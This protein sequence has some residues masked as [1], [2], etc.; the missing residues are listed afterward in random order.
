MQ[1]T[2]A[3]LVQPFWP[4][5]TVPP[6]MPTAPPPPP[7]P[8]VVSSTQQA[9]FPYGMPQSSETGVPLHL[10][11]LLSS[12]SPIPSK[13]LGLASV[14]IY[15]AVMSPTSSTAMSSAVPSTPTSRVLYGAPDGTMY[16]RCTTSSSAHAP[17]GGGSYDTLAPDVSNGAHA[18]PKCYKLEFITTYDSSVESLN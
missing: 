13:A 1:A 11:Q 2:I 14:P 17:F 12:P 18:V 6:V 5:A 4:S 7:L 9:I 3:G 15:T 10:L 8:S 16:Y